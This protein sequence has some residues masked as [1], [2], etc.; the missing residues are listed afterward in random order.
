MGSGKQTN[1][2]VK[3]RIE[4]LADLH[5]CCAGID[6]HKASVTVCVICGGDEAEVA[7]YG[8][9]TNELKQL[10]AWLARKA[11]T[12]IVMESTGVYWK[13]VWQILEQGGFHL[14]LANARQVRN[15]PGRKTDQ[16]DAIWLATLLRKGLIE[17]SFIPPAEVR[18]LRD[19]CRSR[20][21]LLHDR[22]RIVQRLE[23]VLEEANIKLDTV[24]SDLM[25]IS[26]QRMLEKMSEGVTDPIELADL[27]LGKLRPKIPQLVEA[28]EGSFLPHQ[29]FLLKELLAQH[30]ELSERMQRFEEK[31]EEYARPF[32]P[33][34]VR[35]IGIAGLD[36]RSALGVLSEIGADMTRF[37]SAE[38]LARWAVICPGNKESAGKRLSGRT[39]AGNPW[40]RAIL[41]QCAWAATRKKDTY[42]R[43]QFRRLLHRGKKRAIVAVAHSILKVIWHLLR[44]DLDFK[45]LGA[46]YFEKQNLDL[47]KRVCVRKLEKMGFTVTLAPTAA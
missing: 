30:E 27:A 7:Q 33:A 13:P 36:R 42:F 29:L 37:P 5:R 44:R 38:Q 18:A 6:V 4:D 17:G 23:K 2:A 24:V 19:L 40:I 22:T 39:G 10:K 9:T 35:L 25:G 11:V 31:I 47:H 1:R 20:T 43:A 8:T 46:D 21:S 45:D 16:A 3:V 32:E 34:V 15:M 28:L 26:G 12:H 41:V 14:L